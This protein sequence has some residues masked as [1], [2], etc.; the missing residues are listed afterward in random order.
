MLR[1]TPSE[2]CAYALC[3]LESAS[4][5]MRVFAIIEAC[6]T[7]ETAGVSVSIERPYPDSTEYQCEVCSGVQFTGRDAFALV[8][9]SESQFS[10]LVLALE[11][12]FEETDSVSDVCEVQS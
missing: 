12:V 1:F 2:A 11:S 3:Q 4:A 9:T 10:A 5:R 6:D 7:L 8:G